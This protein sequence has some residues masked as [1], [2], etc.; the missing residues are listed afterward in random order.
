MQE[1]AGRAIM[2]ESEDALT[3]DADGPEGRAARS[4][5]DGGWKQIIA[6]Y[7]EEF[8]RYF[9][10]ELHARIDFSRGY[11]LLDADLA[12]LT[13]DAAAGK[14]E[15]DKLIEVHWKEG[16]TDWILIHVEVQAQRDADFAE[17]M[18]RYNCRIWD[19]YG[20]DVISVAL[21]AD[22][23][24]AF[25]PCRYTRGRVGCR[26]EFTF[27]I[28]KLLDYKTEEEL[29]AD[30]SPFAVVSLV[31]LRKL[32]A[33]G[34]MARRFEFKVAETRRLLSNKGWSEDDIR[35][36]FRFLDYV[37]V[38]P[39]ELTVRY[40]QE[41]EI[42]EKELQVPYLTS[43]ERLAREKGIEEGIEKGV[44]QAARDLILQTIEVR[45]GNVPEALRSRI[46]Q[47][48]DSQLLRRFHQRALTAISAADLQF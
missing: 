18:C 42:L 44:E 22:G 13:V 37:L 25:R 14:R 47:C 29:E 19:R 9:F 8:F 11:R 6:D 41:L 40:R 46:E 15:V 36:L 27:P 10:P 1:T 43:I 31:Q 4:D 23:A 2:N 3:R 34:D 21:L 12:K 17:R 28:V 7:L 32:E 24:S 38:L 5:M 20:K 48:H 39:D 45:F 16:G 30:P 26:L 33:A 35:N